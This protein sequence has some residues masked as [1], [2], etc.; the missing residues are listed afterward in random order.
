[1]IPT[2][3]HGVGVR[4]S[5]GNALMVSNGPSGAIMLLPVRYNDAQKF[6]FSVAA[7]NTSGYPINIGSE[8]VRLYLDGQP[9]SVQDFDYLRHSARTTAQRE[10]NLAWT[11][12]AVEYFLTLQEM[13]DH[14]CR[15][16]IAY[17]RA[18]GELQASHD[19]IQRRLPSDHLYPGAD[20]AGDDD[21]R[22]GHGPWRRHPGGADRHPRRHGP[23]YGD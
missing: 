16:D 17:R 20:H 1:M 12:A 9:Y 18:S 6:F 2:A 10:M 13:E 7:F 11:D 19:H 21:H 23:R 5:R 15:H 4:F 22:S 8:D 14:P 3:D